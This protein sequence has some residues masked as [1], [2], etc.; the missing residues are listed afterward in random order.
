[1]QFQ[2]DICGIP[3]VRPA[4]TETT[5]LG[6]AFLAGLAVG[7]WQS[8]DQIERMWAKDKVFTPIMPAGKRDALVAGWHDS[9]RR[10]R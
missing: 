8:I 5:A 9:V 6:A 2:A 10:V 1:M 3:V 4:C 7:F